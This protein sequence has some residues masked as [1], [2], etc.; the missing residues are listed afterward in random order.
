MCIIN[1]GA[2]TK[3]NLETYLM[4][5]VSVKDEMQLDDMPLNK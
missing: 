5:L 1:K 2:H 4:I 3:K